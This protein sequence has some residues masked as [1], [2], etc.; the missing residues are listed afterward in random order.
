MS[1]YLLL[2]CLTLVLVACGGTKNP[3]Y[4][5]TLIETIEQQCPT[6]DPGS[7]DSCIYTLHLENGAIIHTS[8]KGDIKY[9]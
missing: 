7:D 3:Y 8:H 9:K 5:D 2:F 6:N 1:T 4:H